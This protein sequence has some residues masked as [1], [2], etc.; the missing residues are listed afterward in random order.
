MSTGRIVVL[1]CVI[2][3]SLLGVIAAF[4]LAQWFW[5]LDFLNAIGQD[6]AQHVLVLVRK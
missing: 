6:L 1:M 4:Y 2:P 5:S 3:C